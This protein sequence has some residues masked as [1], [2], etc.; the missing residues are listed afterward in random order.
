M[1]SALDM[2]QFDGSKL[3]RRLNC[4]IKKYLERQ[5]SQGEKE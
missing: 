5:D 4:E 2:G 3:G 1:G